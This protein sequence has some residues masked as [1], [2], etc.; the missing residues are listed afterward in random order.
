MI[1]RLR[2]RIERAVLDWA[3]RW[4]PPDRNTG[5]AKKAVLRWQYRKETKCS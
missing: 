5:P 4:P 3:H 2:A 1:R